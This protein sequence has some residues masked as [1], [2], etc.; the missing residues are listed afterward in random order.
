MDSS[1][2]T[3]QGG[4]K[5]YI[6]YDYWYTAML[7]HDHQEDFDSIPKKALETLIVYHPDQPRLTMK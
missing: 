1:V 5:V 3:T 2:E 4:T 6:S 7:E